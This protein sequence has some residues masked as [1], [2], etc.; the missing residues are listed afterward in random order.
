MDNGETQTL[1]KVTLA[2]NR[3]LKK[4]PSTNASHSVEDGEKLISSS[5]R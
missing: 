5:V 4:N 3:N 2:E 1:M